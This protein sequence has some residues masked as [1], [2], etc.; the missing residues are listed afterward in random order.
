MNMNQ[1]HYYAKFKG[2]NNITLTDLLVAYRKA[3]ADCFFDSTFPTS[4]EFAKYEDNLIENLGKLQLCLVLASGF[5]HNLDNLT[6]EFR[7]IPKKLGI[8]DKDEKNEE[9]KNGHT[10]FSDYK[11][12][13]QHL[14]ETKKPEFEFRIVGDFPVETHIISA[15]WVNMVG[16]KF[17]A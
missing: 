15:L 7:L 13:F 16:H 12:A 4:A 10:H 9:T 14:K 17:D 8:K 3:K 6:G 2:W 11:R 5:E 1:E